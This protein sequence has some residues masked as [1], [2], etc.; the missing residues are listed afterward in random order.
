[1]NSKN[2]I[3]SAFHRQRGST[4]VGKAHVQ[5]Q[6]ERANFDP[7]SH[8]NP[9]NFSNLNLTLMIRSMRSTSVQIFIPIRSAGLLPRYMKY[10]VVVTF[11]LVGYTVFFLGHMPRSNPWMDFHDLWLIR[12]V[13][14]GRSFLGLQQYRNSS[15]GNNNNNIRLLRQNDKPRRPNTHEE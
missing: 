5:S 15:R 4:V 12:C 10:Y 3:H 7:Q 1:M 13:A 14:Q 6:W 11:F 8:Q 2:E 9:W